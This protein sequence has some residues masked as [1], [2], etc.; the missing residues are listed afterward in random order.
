MGERNASNEL[1]F[2]ESLFRSMAGITPYHLRD[3]EA[4]HDEARKTELGY[5][6]FGVLSAVWKE[7]IRL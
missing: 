4:K 3:L 7:K 1:Y 6:I 2:T 5:P